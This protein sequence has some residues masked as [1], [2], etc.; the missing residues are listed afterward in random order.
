[1]EKR[2]VIALVLS[3][4]VLL[5]WSA[6]MPKP[7][8]IEN[9]TVIATDTITATAPA[10]PAPAEAIPTMPVAIAQY[11]DP[12][13]DITFNEPSAAIS[14]VVF[15]E[16]QDH[17]FVLDDAFSILDN[18]LVFKSAAKMSNSAIFIHSDAT[19]KIT[20]EFI[21]SN[22]N[23]TIELRI[24]V[25]SLSSQPIKLDIPLSLGIL[26]FKSSNPQSRYQNVIVDTK[27][28]TMYLN[29][30]KETKLENIKFAVLREKYF[31]EITQPQ[32]SGYEAYVRKLSPQLSQVVLIGPGVDLAPGQSVDLKFRIYMGPQE[33]GL[34]N[35]ANAQWSVII[36][37]GTFDFIAQ[38]LLHLLHFF[39]GV[40]HNWGWAI[41]ILSIAVYVV[42]YPLTM[43]Q[44]RS[45]REMQALQPKIEELRKTYKDNPQKLNKEMMELYRIHKVNPFGGCLPLLLQMPIF[46][47]LYQVLLRSIALK[48]A[49]FLWIKDLSEPDRF[50]MLPAS[51]P[52]LGNE[53]NI[54]P[55]LMAIVMF[56]QQKM[57][58]AGSYGSAG[59]S[60][61]QQQ[62]MMSIIFPILFGFIFYRMPSGL[63]L[64]WFVNSGLVVV[65]QFWGKHLRIVKQA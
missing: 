55:I 4:V 50:M 1:M 25:Q 8:H 10:L 44:M 6:M 27:E 7:Q 24:N 13:F 37:Y 56:F 33:I 21:F 17:K 62:K 19:K 65:S 43:K 59:G 26:D 5:L 3:V 23:Y 41:I 63:V 11:Q 20:K 31:A 60:S 22:S 49:H 51:L 18:S 9:K 29:G 42:L 57:S 52:V 64:Y 61:E 45:M 58:M 54:L 53:I 38:L 36:N 2:S 15:K 39:Y 16:Y 40:V 14:Q 35:Q 30:R 34:L 28:K 48:G 47:A 12:R 46:F 32:D